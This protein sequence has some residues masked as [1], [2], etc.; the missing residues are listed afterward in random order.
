MAK[1]EF[2]LKHG[3]NVVGS[4]A[5]DINGAPQ[6][7]L[8][9]FS[10]RP[11]K[12]PIV[13]NDAHLTSNGGL[14]YIGPLQ[15]R[16]GFLSGNTYTVEVTVLNAPIG[17]IVELSTREIQT[18]SGD[19]PDTV[20]GVII[21]PINNGA[22]NQS[23]VAEFQVNFSQFP[24]DP[25]VIFWYGFNWI[26]TTTAGSFKD[27]TPQAVT[28]GGYKLT[29]GLKRRLK[30]EVL[31]DKSI[32]IHPGDYGFWVDVFLGGGGGGMT[33]RWADSEDVV[34]GEN[35]GSVTLYAD[36]PETILYTKPW[37]V[38][39]RADSAIFLGFAEGGRG[40]TAEDVPGGKGGRSM[41][42][43]NKWDAVP[44]RRTSL[45]VTLIEQ[46]NGVTGAWNSGWVEATRFG[47]YND[48]VVNGVIDPA[49]NLPKAGASWRYL[50][51]FI[52]GAGS[53][54][55]MRIHYRRT[56]ADGNLPIRPLNL[57]MFANA[58]NPLS[59]ISIRSSYGPTGS[60]EVLAPHSKITKNGQVIQ[61]DNSRD[62]PLLPTSSKGGNSGG[63]RP[64]FNVANN[65]DDGSIGILDF[66]YYTSYA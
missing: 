34:E 57:R 53:Y 64:T 9:Y 31:A 40:S 18:L 22:T 58:L 61:L 52:S 25:A 20:P 5:L 21:A 24:A 15:P 44:E 47:A 55:K 48:P 26:L 14:D 4:T 28:H 19:R 11:N 46:R 42:Y 30:E 36:S 63:V 38:D 54:V 65:G 45:Q 16:S 41:A 62:L 7:S 35:G 59:A 37:N 23:R 56:A 39:V 12:V 29:A 49:T 51:G 17:T 13:M 8:K 1:L 10:A 60:G 3:N 43:V 6:F 33:G 2:D 32:D 27:P 50:N 66:G